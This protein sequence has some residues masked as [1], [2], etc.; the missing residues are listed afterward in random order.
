MDIGYWVIMGILA[1]IGMVVS[2]RLKSKF[3]HYSKIGVRNGKSGQQVAE[4]APLLWY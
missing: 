1:V 4:Y 3:A 2:G